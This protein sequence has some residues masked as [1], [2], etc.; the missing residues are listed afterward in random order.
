MPDFGLE[1]LDLALIGQHL[2][3]IKGCRR[4][5]LRLAPPEA[6]YNLFDALIEG[7][8]TPL[9][10][11]SGK[12]AT[13]T[14]RKASVAIRP[15]PRATSGQTDHAA[16]AIGIPEASREGNRREPAAVPIRAR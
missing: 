9:G 11:E 8:V 2:R 10:L 7:H 1:Q 13:G 14:R 15:V 4:R 16:A 12:S 3:T 6:T 5:L